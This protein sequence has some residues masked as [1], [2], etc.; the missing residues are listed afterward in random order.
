MLR[1][2]F[3]H[4]NLADNTDDLKIWADGSRYIFTNMDRRIACLEL[5]LR[6]PLLADIFR[7]RKSNDDKCK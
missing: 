1:K 3:Q 7:S 2:S 5:S 6:P 4:G